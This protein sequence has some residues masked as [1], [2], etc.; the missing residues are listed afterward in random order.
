MSISN[1]GDEF[2]E[3]GDADFLEILECRRE[4]VL[5]TDA[6]TAER[7]ILTWLGLTPKW[8]IIKIYYN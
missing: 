2:A 7:L 8:L 6:G 3:E 5:D 1:Y 4:K